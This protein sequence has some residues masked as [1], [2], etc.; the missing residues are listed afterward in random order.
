MKTFRNIE[1]TIRRNHKLNKNKFA[2]SWERGIYNLS[3]EITG[4]S[5]KAINKFKIYIKSIKILENHYIIT[6]I[7]KFR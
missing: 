1:Y 3:T 5:K 6:T 2:M 7:F 4:D